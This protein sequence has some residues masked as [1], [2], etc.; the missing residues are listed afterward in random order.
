MTLEYVKAGPDD[1]ALLSEL[2]CITFIE[3]YSDQVPMEEM[4]P[5]LAEALNERAIA[6]ELAEPEV[7]YYF[8]YAHSNLASRPALAGFIMLR[9]RYSSDLLDGAPATYINRFYLRA[10]YWGSG[11]ARQ[12]MDFCEAFAEDA[13][14]Q[15]LWLQVWEQNNRAI[16]F[17]QKCGF[18]IFGI[19]DFHMGDVVHRDPVMRKGVAT[20]IPV[21]RTDQ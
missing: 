7:H 5:Y 8:V 13:G 21:T 9:R 12:M 19:A 17:Y 4:Q 16:S 11:L 3:A 14:V 15:W 6:K 2:S 1:A 20:G 18:E 10:Q